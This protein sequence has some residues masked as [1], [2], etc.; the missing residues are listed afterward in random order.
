MR[1]IKFR[2]WSI[3]D[4]RMSHQE[5]NGYFK[6]AYYS[7][8][9]KA[10]QDVN[11]GILIQKHNLGSI[12]LMQYTGLKDKNGK[13]IFEGDIVKL[14]EYNFYFRVEYKEAGYMLVNNAM[15]QYELSNLAIKNG[16]IIGNIYESPELLNN[17]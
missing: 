12:I 10:L 1:E 2:A 3:P 5:P 14:K 9:Y 15:C 6:G 8:D 16:E 13:E 4:K 7:T 17:N 11:L